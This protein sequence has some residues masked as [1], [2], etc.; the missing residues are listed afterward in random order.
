MGRGD[1]RARMEIG[2]QE[3]MTSSPLGREDGRLNT[4]NS[5]TRRSLMPSALLT[6]LIAS[7]ISAS[8]SSTPE[9]K[10]SALLGRL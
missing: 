9:Q 10:D 4:L 2:R 3:F 8:M 1:V 5:P 6:V 7:L